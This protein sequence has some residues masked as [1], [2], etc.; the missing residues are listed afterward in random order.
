MPVLTPARLGAVLLTGAAL[1]ALPAAAATK[2]AKPKPAA[3]AKAKAKPNWE[4]VWVR[5]GG[6]TDPDTPI[7]ILTG[8]QSPPPES[9]WPPLT[10]EY[11]ARYAAI[12]DGLKRGERL[13][14]PT[15]NCLPAGFPWMMNMPY[16]ME[17][18]Q[19]ATKLTIIAE[20][21]GQTRRIYIGAPLP[22]DVEPTYFGTSVG[23][24]EGDTLVVETVG[25]RD[26][27]ALND[28]GLPHSDAM[29][30][31]ERWSFKD[32]VLTDEITIVDPKALTQP[33]TTSRRYKKMP[34]DFRMMEYVCENNRDT[35]DMDTAGQKLK[36][37]L[38][39]KPPA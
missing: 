36:Q 30:V 17:I 35:V 25:L 38:T 8:G 28:S 6:A 9:T 31:T 18:H 14:D 26:D 37:A 12:V 3:A 19:T 5:I 21:M 22:T 16:P 23:R 33:W 39:A 10:P 29:R 11:K 7:T 1:A 27:T 34:A 24:W 20:W 13:N 15:A 4:G 32:G 2:A